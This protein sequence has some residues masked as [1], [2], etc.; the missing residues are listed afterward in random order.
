ME[1][2]IIMVYH[3]HLKVDFSSHQRFMGCN[4]L[5][6]KI[7]AITSMIVARKDMAREI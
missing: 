6:V 1:F 7:S 3:S 4:E 2:N 5:E